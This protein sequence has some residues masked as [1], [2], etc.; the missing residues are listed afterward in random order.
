MFVCLSPKIAS[1]TEGKTRIQAI[2]AAPRT[3]RHR[4]CQDTGQ[5]ISA[6]QWQAYKTTKFLCTK[7]LGQCVSWTKGRLPLSPGILEHI[8][9]LEW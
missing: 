3:C 4:R 8:S 6:I 2:S 7:A 5:L 1:V 9:M